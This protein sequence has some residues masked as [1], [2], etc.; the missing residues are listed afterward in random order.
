MR[1]RGASVRQGKLMEKIVWVGEWWTMLRKVSIC[2]KI[3]LAIETV[4]VCLLR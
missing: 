2:K 4:T 1:V 3:F